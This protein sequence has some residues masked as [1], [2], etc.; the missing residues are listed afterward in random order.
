M[1][2]GA[3]ILVIF[4]MVGGIILLAL[5][6]SAQR[7]KGHL[8]LGRAELK[9]D[10]EK[11]W[12]KSL[13]EATK[14]PAVPFLKHQCWLEVRGT[15][16]RYPL[17]QDR[18]TYIGQVSDNKIRF[19]S[20]SFESNL[21]VIYWV[22]N[23]FRINNLSAHVPTRVNGRAIRSQNL[24]DGNTIQFGHVKTIFRDSSKGQQSAEKL[25]R[26]QH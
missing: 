2:S 4:I 22:E 18:H 15:R 9:I 6:L 5:I 14:K 7:G 19:S 24:G 11:G 10:F 23:R 3:T 20:Q 13:P 21:A 17:L 16:W 26:R 12:H 8:R 25:R 1:D